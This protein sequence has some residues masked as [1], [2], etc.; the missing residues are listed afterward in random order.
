M[1]S[2]ASTYSTATESA[3]MHSAIASQ[4]S[5]LYSSEFL[6]LL[7]AKKKPISLEVLLVI[8]KLE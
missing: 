4:T 7:K 2:A 1:V 3:S 8:C 6:T 5:T